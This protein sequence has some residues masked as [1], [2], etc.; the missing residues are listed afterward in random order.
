MGLRGPCPPAPGLQ[1]WL[2]YSGHGGSLAT[3]RSTVPGEPWCPLRISTPAAWWRRRGTFPRVPLPTWLC[4]LLPA[5]WFITSH[6]HS[7]LID[8]V[9]T[10]LIFSCDF[11][12]ECSVH[13]KFLKDIPVFLLLL[14]WA[15]HAGCFLLKP[16]SL[17]VTVILGS[18]P[19]LLPTRDM[20]RT[21]QASISK[22]AKIWERKQNEGLGVGCLSSH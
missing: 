8:P 18:F 11:H 10:F 20:Q 9:L 6:L 7:W 5:S 14:L 17:L 22:D 12:V 4:D 15:P 1:S 19:V 16:P 3:Q 21:L 2:P 13:P